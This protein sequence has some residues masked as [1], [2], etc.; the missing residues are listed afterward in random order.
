L[1]TGCIPITF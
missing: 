1:H